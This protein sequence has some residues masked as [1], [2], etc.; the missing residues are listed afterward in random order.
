MNLVEA[1][2]QPPEVTAHPAAKLEIWPEE[3]YTATKFDPTVASEF[4][5]REDE[6]KYIKKLIRRSVPENV[7]LLLG[8][9]SCGKT[10]LLEEL[11]KEDEARFL[12]LNCG[13]ET[14]TTSAEM[15][16]ALRARA[17]KL[18]AALG[19]PLR[20]IPEVLKI[21]WISQL[22]AVW[23]FPQ[24]DKDA[25][26]ASI[27]LEATPQQTPVFIIDE[28][29]ELRKWMQTPEEKKN[30]DGLLNFLKRICKEQNKAQVIL[31][32]SESF[33][34][35]WLEK[36]G[37]TPDS[38]MDVVLGDVTGEEA[39]RFVVGGKDS[40]GKVWPG[41]INAFEDIPPL[42]KEDWVKVWAMCGGNIKLLRMCVSNADVLGDWEKAVES[43]GDASAKN[44]DDAWLYAT[45][46]SKGVGGEDRLWTSEDY[47]LAVGLI[48]NAAPYYSVPQIVIAA[49]LEKDER[50]FKQGRGD[51][52]GIDVLLSMIEYN[53]LS[54]RPYSGMAK[55]IPREVFFRMVKG[56]EGIVEEKKDSVVVMPSPA[57]LFAALKNNRLRRRG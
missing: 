46:F 40:S 51:I 47:Q 10:A 29:N 11:M 54:V 12:H 8:P 52:A 1:F 38:R 26:A 34:V 57:H 39:L 35:T 43:V 7:I 22:L 36:N 17:T 5:N 27:L 32:T 6:L 28:A 48:A 9:G 16:E 20:S 55:D 2:R 13:L 30:L 49:E 50:L 14:V 56:E 18:P 31:A 41:Q 45:S 23:G 19:I 53:V 15:A 3:G 4:F 44:V 25:V 37:F 21:S 24:V 33:M 42:Q